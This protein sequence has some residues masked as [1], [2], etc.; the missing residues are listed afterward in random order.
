MGVGRGIT[1]LGSAYSSFARRS[2]CT[3]G[4]AAT[5]LPPCHGTYSG[6]SAEITDGLAH[7]QDGDPS[8]GF[9]QRGRL[10]DQLYRLRD[11]HEVAGHF[12]VR[13]PDGAARGDLPLEERDDTA[14]GPE[15]VAESHDP[16]IRGASLQ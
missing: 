13:H 4:W 11:G 10:E 1:P 15:D 14:V 6:T 16:K 9:R 8:R 3:A 12:R 2:R 7:L 5:S